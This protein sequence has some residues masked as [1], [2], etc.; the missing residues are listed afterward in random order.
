M[1]YRHHPECERNHLRR[2][3]PQVEPFRSE[4]WKQNVLR[5]QA[6]R[7][8]PV[9]IAKGEHTVSIRALDDHIVIDQ[10]MMDFKPLRHSYLFP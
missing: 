7:K 8:M 10:W 6:V 5:G 4:R 3:Q 2:N 9:S 1:A